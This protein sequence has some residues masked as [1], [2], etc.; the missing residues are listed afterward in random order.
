MDSFFLWPK[1]MFGGRKQSFWSLSFLN[2]QKAKVLL[3]LEFDTEDQVL[4]I[5]ECCMKGWFENLAREEPA[6]YGEPAPGICIHIWLIMWLSTIC[7]FIFSALL[8]FF[9]KRKPL[10]IFRINNEI[11]VFIFYNLI[12]I[13]PFFLC[14]QIF[15]K[16]FLNIY[17]SL[18]LMIKKWAKRRK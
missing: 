8:C 9:V 6:L 18:H 14:S 16:F 2:W 5:L 3:K 10:M 17:F 7:I 1:T 13:K 4:L 12:C 11:Q 15:S